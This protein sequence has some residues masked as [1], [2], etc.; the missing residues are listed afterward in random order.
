MCP[1]SINIKKLNLPLSSFT[2]VFSYTE[3]N[4][5]LYLLYLKRYSQFEFNYETR[6]FTKLNMIFKTR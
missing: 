4:S 1:E 2:Y 3:E 5:L 6:D